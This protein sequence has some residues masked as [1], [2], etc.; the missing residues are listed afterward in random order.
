MPLDTSADIELFAFDWVP[1]IAKGHVRDLRARWAMEEAGIPYRTRLL[2]VADKPAEYAL[3]QPFLQVPALVDG[4]TWVFESGAILLHLGRKSEA[5]MP[6]DEA[7]RADTES[8]LLAAFNSVETFA[9]EI[10]F[11]HIFSAGEEWTKLREPGATK[12][13]KS[14]LEHVSSALGDK[15]YL[16]G[17]FTIA[18]IAM[19]TVFRDLDRHIPLDEWPNLGAYLERCTARPAFRR[20]L[21][22]QMADFTGVQPEGFPA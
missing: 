16:T 14:R 18:D 21:D 10:Y 19:T 13:M 8:W 5:L 15:D 12:L 2:K 17:R 3:H 1:D 9:F 6:A 22:A 7:G 11:I 4:G 20:A